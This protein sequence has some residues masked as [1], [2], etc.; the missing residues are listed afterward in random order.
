MSH[1]AFSTIRSRLTWRSK[2]SNSNRSP[3]STISARKVENSEEGRYIELNALPKNTATAWAT[4]LSDRA[5]E[6][7][8]AEKT[9]PQGI[10]RT[11]DYQVGHS[12][13]QSYVGV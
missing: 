13:S 4:G 5:D 10:L 12:P 3:R 1:S 11:D 9:S 8:L 7:S 6:G 2:S